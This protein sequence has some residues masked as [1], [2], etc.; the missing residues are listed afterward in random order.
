MVG[1]QGWISKGGGGSGGVGSGGGPGVG[2]VGVVGSRG[3]VHRGP[4]V[5]G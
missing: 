2:G 1:V 4:R 3:W 5:G